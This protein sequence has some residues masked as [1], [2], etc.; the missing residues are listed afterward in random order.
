MDR[1]AGL[2]DPTRAAG[3]PVRPAADPMSPTALP[4]PYEAADLYDQVLESFDAD[5]PFWLEEARRASSE[6]RGSPVL[7]VSCGTG[8]VLL[9]LLAHG[10]DADG[11]DLYAPM[12]ERLSAKARERGVAPALYRADMRDFTTP[13]RYS[14][15]FIP[16][17]GFAHCETVDDQLRCLRC[18]REHLEEGGAL[19]LH[20]SYPGQAY[21][22]SSVPDGERVLEAETPRPAGGSARLWDTRRK[23]RVAQLQH[24][25]VE[26]EE[27]DP[28]GQLERT[29]RFE[30]RQRWVYR[31]ELELLFR[32]AGFDRWEILGGW[33]RSP[34]AGDEDQ[35]MAF[36]WKDRAP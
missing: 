12:L 1:V 36:A 25:I 34:L 35:M 2:S 6:R 18:C 4:S 20:M 19:V 15:V 16:F 10:I 11:V 21:W 30:T 22:L 27:L 24:S 13:R 23:D 17:N 7:E 28:A 26:V 9:H 3:D 8:R 29:H 14:R 33:D 31:F 5:L 32:L